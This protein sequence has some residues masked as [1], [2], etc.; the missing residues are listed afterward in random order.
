MAMATIPVRLLEL[1]EEVKED[2]KADAIRLFVPEILKAAR[3]KDAMARRVLEDSALIANLRDGNRELASQRDEAQ[4][5]LRYARALI[6]AQLL[7]VNSVLVRKM[8]NNFVRDSEDFERR[9]VSISDAK[10]KHA[11]SG[12]EAA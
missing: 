4:Q 8:A 1:M 10:S 3:E 5:Q 9:V 11:D 2:T 7:D 12:R 6:K